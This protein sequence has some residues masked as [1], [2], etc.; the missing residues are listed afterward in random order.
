MAHRVLTDP[1][2][3]DPFDDFRQLVWQIRFRLN[4]ATFGLVEEYLG[5]FVEQ[6]LMPTL[7]QW[8]NALVAQHT[9]MMM[10]R[11]IGD[12]A[13]AEASGESSSSDE[14]DEDFD[15]NFDPKDFG[16]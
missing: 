15:Q 12:E 14:G 3:Y 10:M 11:A 2:E 16:W 5:S 9:M 6:V 8:Q 13:M 7:N 4:A 1:T